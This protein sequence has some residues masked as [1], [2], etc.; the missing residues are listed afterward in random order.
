MIKRIYKGVMVW[1]IYFIVKYM[2]PENKPLMI[3]WVELKLGYITKM[4][5]DFWMEDQ[6][7]KQIEKENGQN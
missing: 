3:K 1:I 4:D 6:A 5:L 2:I 7:R